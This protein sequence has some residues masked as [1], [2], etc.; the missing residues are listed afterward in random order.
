M[1][2]TRNGMEYNVSSDSYENS[3]EFSRF[4]EEEGLSALEVL[5]ILLDW[6]GT[7]LTSEAMMKNTFNCEFG[8]DVK[9]EEEGEE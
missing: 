3:L 2:Y 8:L 6:H 4:I 5:D 1:I 9:D 7:A